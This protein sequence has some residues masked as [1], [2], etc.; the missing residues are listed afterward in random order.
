MARG[1]D[2][3]QTEYP[4]GFLLHPR[5]LLSPGP[6]TRH[7]NPPISCIRALERESHSWLLREPGCLLGTFLRALSAVK[8]PIGSEGCVSHPRLSLNPPTKDTL[9]PALSSPKQ[10]PWAS[11]HVGPL[12]RWRVRAW[13]PS[14][15]GLL[16]AQ[17]SPALRLP[18]APGA[19]LGRGPDA[20]GLLLGD[21]GQGPAELSP[22]LSP[23]PS[24]AQ[25]QTWP[26]APLQGAPCR[27]NSGTSTEEHSLAEPASP[28]PG[29]SDRAR[30]MG[31]ATAGQGPSLQHCF[32]SHLKRL[33]EEASP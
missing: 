19:Q 14:S 17:A 18:T 33:S 20:T 23:T 3:S 1:S 11:L 32:W 4:Q 29:V 28:R 24:P 25:P 16:A 31:E 27:G 21:T 12:A 7:P 15:S 5:C 2:F 9:S 8:S 10:A 30:H 22:C 26:P 6:A 13:H